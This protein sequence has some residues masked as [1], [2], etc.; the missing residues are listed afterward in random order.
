VLPDADAID[1]EPDTEVV[2]TF[3]EPIEGTTVTKDNIQLLDGGVP[4][5]GTLTHQGEKV[6]FTPDVPLALFAELEVAV[7]TGVTDDAGVSLLEAHSSRFRVRDGTWH[8][9][10]AVV[11]TVYQLADVLP[12]TASGDALVAWT[13]WNGG[14]IYCPTSANW[15]NRGVAASAQPAVFT[16]EDIPDCRSVTAGA[17][18]DGVGVVVWQEDFEYAQQF[19]AGE[20]GAPKQ[21]VSKYGSSHLYTSAVAP[22][23][24]VSFFQH[25]SDGTDV[26]LTDS[27]GTWS[28]NRDDISNATGLSSVNVAFDAEGNGFAVWAA[29]DASSRQHILVS[30][31]TTTSGVWSAAK[32]LRGSLAESSAVNYMR[33][34]PAVA[35][36]A[37]GRALVLWTSRDG[38]PTNVLMASRFIDEAQWSDPLPLAGATSVIDLLEPPSLVF[39]GETF[40]AAWTERVASSGTIRAARFNMEVDQFAASEARSAPRT[41]LERMPRLVADTHHHLL[42]VWAATHPS[43]GQLVYSRY[44]ALGASWSGPAEVSG[45]V[46]HDSAPATIRPMPLGMNASGVGALM[47]GDEND[48]DGNLSVIRLASFH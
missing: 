33:G 22:D 47:W 41:A 42:L 48:E 31:F 2:I 30:R 26:W 40:V 44:D 21:P 36:D 6:T 19:R 10:N 9:T 45:G 29:R 32:I 7:L 23:G 27:E 39:D 17:N 16:G 8:T 5:A 28:P 11:G 25:V 12:V 35:V 34:A 38:S 14:G 24:S 1:I 13:A 46:V 37:D 3:S 4:I 43:G 20:W 15:F 18:A